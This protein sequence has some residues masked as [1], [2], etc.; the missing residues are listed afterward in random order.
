MYHQYFIFYLPII[1]INAG[2]GSRPFFKQCS[3]WSFPSPPLT[4]IYI[5][6]KTRGILHIKKTM[7]IPIKIKEDFSLVT[8]Q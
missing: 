7:T 5:L 8:L 2:T 1:I 6:T 4:I 3:K